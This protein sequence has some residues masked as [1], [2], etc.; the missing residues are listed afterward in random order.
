MKKTGLKFRAWDLIAVAL[1]LLT[2]GLLE[3]GF[4]RKTL[5]S[6]DLCVRIFQEG[7][8]LREESLNKDLEIEISGKYHNRI[9]IEDGKVEVMEADCPGKDCVHTG[10]ISKAGSA[11]VCLPNRLEIRIE[12]WG[13]ASSDVDAIAE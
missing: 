4:L 5:D 8:L 13:D 2:A 3:L 9:R 10:S 11:I 6:E 12:N 7:K 1:V